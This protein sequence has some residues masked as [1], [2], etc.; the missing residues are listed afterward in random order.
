MLHQ[1]PVL[2]L[3]RK[4]NSWHIYY[5]AAVN[6]HTGALHIKLMSGSKGMLC[7]SD[8]PCGSPLCTPHDK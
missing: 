4:Y 8:A 5:Y 1:P 2:L 7:A 6:W 3:Q